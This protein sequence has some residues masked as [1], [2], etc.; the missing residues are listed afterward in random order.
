MGLLTRA[1]RFHQGIKILLK[2]E[3]VADAIEKEE[4]MGY[5]IKIGAAKALRDFIITALAVG[6]VAISAYFSV[7][8]HIGAVLGFLPDS[9]EHALIPVA[10]AFFV[11]L[12]NWLRERGK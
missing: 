4:K 9:I 1:K 2:L 5:D 3:R 10:S 8:E 7:P 6:A 11:F 12:T